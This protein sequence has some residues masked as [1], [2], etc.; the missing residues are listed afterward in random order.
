VFDVAFRSFVPDVIGRARILEANTRFAT[1]DAVAEITTP[2]LTGALVQVIAAP[3]AILLDAAT[4]VVSALCISSI[5]RSEVQRAPAI[6][7]VRTEIID[8]LRAVVQSPL[9]RT[10]AGYDAARSFFGTFIGA[11][12][13]LFGLRELELSPLLVGITVGVGGASNLFGTLIVQ[14]L[15]R[16]LGFGRTILGAVI[17]GCVGPMLIALAPSN[18]VG[19]FSVLVAAQ[20]LDLIHPLYDVNALTLRQMSTP[21]E[22][23]G[24][25]NATMRVIEQGVIPFGALAGGMLASAIGVRPTLLVA[26]AGI[27]I[28]AV[29]VAANFRRQ[30][31][32]G[33][34]LQSRLGGR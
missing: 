11:L 22:L 25:V 9:L 7:D 32:Q 3:L 23:L 13:V 1:I 31:Q 24:R 4:F 28:G 16:R 20:A 2:G 19:G 34:D 6:T 10:F 17:V 26:A 29:W 15:T 21:D 12:Y 30:W 33:Q 27:G 5:N 18:P 14:R 8:G